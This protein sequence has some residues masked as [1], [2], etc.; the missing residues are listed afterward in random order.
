[1]I[2]DIIDVTVTLSPDPRP[3]EIVM[4]PHR[5]MWATRQER[6][7]WRREVFDLLQPELEP[8]TYDVLYAHQERP[9]ATQVT[10]DRVHHAL[11]G[12]LRA[13]GVSDVFAPLV[14]F[15]ADARGIPCIIN[16]GLTLTPDEVRLFGEQPPIDRD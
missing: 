9:Q 12:H 8:W 4:L 7:A 3:I 11:R 14:D 13:A 2:D 16:V 6:Y 5:P 10:L 15:A 1:M